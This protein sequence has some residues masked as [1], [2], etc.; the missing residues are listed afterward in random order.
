MNRLRIPLWEWGAL[1]VILLVA[2]GTRV[3]M[4]SE[5]PPGWRDDELINIHVLSGQVLAGE[6]VVYFTGASGHEP[7]YHTLHAGIVAL[8]GMNPLG[9]HLLSIASGLVTVPL[10]YVLA[11]RLL[12]R[13]TALI[14]VAL[15]AASF[16][17][18]MYSR[19][20]LRHAMVLPP[21]LAASYFLWSDST[22]ARSSLRRPLLAGLLIAAALYT[23][24]VSR[25]LPLILL[26]FCVYLS[27]FHRK[28]SGGWWRRVMVGLVLAAVL[29]APLWAAVSRGRSEAA[30]AGIGAD[31]RID[32]LAIPLRELLAGNPRPFLETTWTT[33]GMFH[34]GGDPEWLYNLPGRP[35]F[36]PLGAVLFLAGLGICLWRWR[37]AESGFLLVWLAVG[38][39]PAMV[40]YPPASFG[41]TI[42]AQ[43]ATYML[44]AL[45]LGI[46][47]PQLHSVL[48]PLL[49]R[50]LPWMVC[51]LLLAGVGGTI[52][53]RD[54][55]DYFIAWP[56]RDEVRF[57]YRGDYRDAARYLTD[58]TAEDVAVGS[59]LMGPWDRLALL[60]DLER[61]GL[62]VRLFNPDRAVLFPAEHGAL[63]LI[64][65]HPR[66]DPVVEDLLGAPVAMLGEELWVYEL[67]PSRDLLGTERLADFENGLSLLDTVSW[68][69]EAIGP[70]DEIQVALVWQVVNSLLLPE[71]PVVANPP[72]PGVYSGPR[73]AVFTHLMTAQGAFLAGD[74]GLWVDP[75]TL[76]PGD[77]F[78]QLHRFSL[79]NGAEPGP[80]VLEVGLYDPL[81][82][83]RWSAMDLG[84]VAE[85]DRYS[86][87]VPGGEE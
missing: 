25:F 1:V 13:S 79:P 17:S 5:V 37:R 31:A 85:V 44:L 56:G 24:T 19:V 57:L 72:P 62:R 42:L 15:L 43:P 64:T 55:R 32:E 12:G 53:V 84:G 45:P 39:S 30:S 47:L 38:V 11:R 41:H 20:A 28:L 87:P 27:L 36:G 3:W 69:A 35:V 86:L 80:Y 6:P 61:D 40:T 33:L 77:L 66:P 50:N 8:V 73:L 82:G 75:T 46:G 21:T 14:T 67:S 65:Q 16:W 18:L 48:K 58:A 51:A 2:W 63:A 26:L 71:I 74:D 70:G 76:L 78:L 59:A 68:S 34:A 60:N 81:T 52:L 23:Y 83:D 54:L 49:P 29:T 4:P 22:A 7:L 10:A 9:G